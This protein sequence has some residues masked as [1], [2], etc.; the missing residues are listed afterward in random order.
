MMQAC[1]LILNSL[2]R[3]MLFL[4]LA[5]PCVY[6]ETRPTP[7][8]SIYKE[9]YKHAVLTPL[10]E[11]LN[12]SMG[13]VCESV[14]WLFRDIVEYFKFI[15]FKKNLKI[16]LNSVG[17]Y[18]VVCAI[19]RNALACLYGNHTSTFFD[20]EPP[21]LQEYSI[22]VIILTLQKQK[23]VSFIFCKQGGFPA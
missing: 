10:Q 2:I 7:I 1:W 5:G 11:A 21:T 15:D 13:G 8:E 17:K 18:Y 12:T 19:F 6:K 22:F 20:L 23:V 3:E 14:E 4:P 16:R 9:S